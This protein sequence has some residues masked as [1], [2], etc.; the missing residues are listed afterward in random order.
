MIKARRERRERDE[1][2]RD[3]GERNNGWVRV[4]TRRERRDSVRRRD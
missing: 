4:R 1:R 2:E 3:T